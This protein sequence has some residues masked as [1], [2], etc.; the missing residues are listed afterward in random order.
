MDGEGEVGDG[1]DVCEAMSL[2]ELGEVGFA[3]DAAAVEDERRPCGD[4]VKG[5]DEARGVGPGDEGLRV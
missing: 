2:R 4:G 1:T 5:K 3:D